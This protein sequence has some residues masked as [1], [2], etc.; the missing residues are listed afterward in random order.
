MV[1]LPVVPID[2]I[3][4]TF[5]FSPE[6]KAVQVG[7]VTS[8]VP[9]S[10]G[11]PFGA[12]F[13]PRVVV[14]IHRAELGPFGRQTSSQGRT[15]VFVKYAISTFLIGDAKFIDQDGRSVAVKVFQ[16]DE[17]LKHELVT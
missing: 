6:I 9:P 14:S 8:A 17:H 1:S 4:E 16:V 3:A 10:S 5:V 2:A 13:A 11:E 15:K 7:I 12:V